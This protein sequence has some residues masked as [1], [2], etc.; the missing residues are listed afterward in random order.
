MFEKRRGKK[1]NSNL[2]ITVIVY[3]NRSVIQ[4]A[5]E[6]VASMCSEQAYFV[7]PQTMSFKELNAGFCENI[8]V[9]TETR[10]VRI[11]YMCPILIING[12]IKYR[13]V[14]ISSDKDVRIMFRTYWQYV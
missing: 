9:G 6:G 13:A 4:N 1:I 12:N 7:I 10:M 2:E 11:R 14:R 5:D 3:Y 8:N